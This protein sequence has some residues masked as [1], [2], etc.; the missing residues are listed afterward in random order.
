MW[1]TMT[2]RLAAAYGLATLALCAAP[3]AADACGN[4]YLN[5]Q[6]PSAPVGVQPTVKNLGPGEVYFS[7]ASL[8]VEDL[9]PNPNDLVRVT[10]FVLGPG[11]AVGAGTHHI[12]ASVDNTPYV[13]QLAKHDVAA[14]VEICGQP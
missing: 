2:V 10:G 11:E 8:P 7:L 4:V 9:S 5:A 14:T 6:H 12:I 13:V 1:D 3:A